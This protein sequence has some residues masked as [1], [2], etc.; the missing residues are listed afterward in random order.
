[1]HNGPLLAVKPGGMGAT[2]AAWR[3]AGKNPQRVGSGVFHQG[4]FFL[5]DA[6][7]FVECLDPKSGEPIWKERL[8]GNLWG[9]ILLADGKIYVSSLEGDTYVLATGPKYQLLARNKLGE[10]MY[11]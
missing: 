3:Q 1:G 5:A 2:T 8:E 10:P 11:A 9:S 4:R 6:P 7:G